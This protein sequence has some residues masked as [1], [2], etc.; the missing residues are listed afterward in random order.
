M[1]KIRKELTGIDSKYYINV[2][3]FHLKKPASSL[4]EELDELPIVKVEI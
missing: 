1:Y 3:V 4:T 2:A